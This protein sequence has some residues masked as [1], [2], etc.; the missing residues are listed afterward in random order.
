M[1]HDARATAT[2]G[3]SRPGLG[4]LARGPAGMD[5]AMH[6]QSLADPFTRAARWR[7]IG[8][9]GASPRSNGRMREAA[10]WKPA[11]DLPIRCVGAYGQA[12][13]VGAHG[14]PTVTQKNVCL[15]LVLHD[16][17]MM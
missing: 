13:P 2:G 15:S 8:G 11:L 17:P 14:R 7:R 10:R 5:G 9:P 1:W 3:V 6:A 12:K 4:I 16:T